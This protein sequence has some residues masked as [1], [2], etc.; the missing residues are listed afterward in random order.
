MVKAYFKK[1]KIML[2]VQDFI[3]GGIATFKDGNRTFLIDFA[4]RATAF[5][6]NLI[7]SLRLSLA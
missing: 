3:I 1:K 2:E 6:S 4:L 5:I 7:T